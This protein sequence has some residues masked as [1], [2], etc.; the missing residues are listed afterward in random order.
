MKT[1]K[2]SLIGALALGVL[3][4]LPGAARAANWKS[5]TPGEDQGRSCIRIGAQ[6]FDYYLL[7]EERPTVLRVRGPQRLKIITRYLFGEA[8]A[9]GARYRLMVRVDG[10]EELRRSFNASNLPSAGLCD[11]DGQVAGLKRV[12]LSV[13]TG[14][15]DI[16][17]L[18]EV[19]G[20]G[21]IAARIFRESRGRK[22]KM[23]NFSPVEY[24]GIY[25][26]QFDSGTQS[27][28]YHFSEN[29][30]LEFTVIGPT[31]L[32]IDTRL[33]FNHTM[34]GST[35]YRLEVMQNG[36]AL[37]RFVYH[38][39]KISSASYIERRDILPGER[40]RMRLTV[41]RGRQKYE[42]HCI[43]PQTCGVAARI[44]IPEADLQGK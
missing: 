5:I 42:I 35:V 20:D 9:Q 24:D 26:L 16:Q 13:P 11:R 44:R 32:E 4:I 30:P 38:T 15:H 28:Y 37:P 40:K 19:P 8:D 31:T 12:Y 1:M 18:G 43:G 33:D 27:T 2:S 41:P 23:V 3:L 25:S 36:E 17:I 7:D 29:A 10:R 39:K 22:A 6:E 21:R 34:N 14:M